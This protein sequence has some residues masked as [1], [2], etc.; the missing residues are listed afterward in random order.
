MTR[1]KT[2]VQEKII[3]D[4]EAQDQPEH[5]KTVCDR[6]LKSKNSQRLLLIYQQI[7]NQTSNIIIN[8]LEE[9]ELCLS[10]LVIKQNGELKVH[11]RI[12]QAIFDRN[13]VEMNLLNSDS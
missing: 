10:G 5:L 1:P 13:W 6:I 3:H 7:L 12:Y 4:W 8:S 9:K 11:N 2:L